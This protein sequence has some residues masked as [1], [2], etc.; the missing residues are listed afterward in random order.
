MKPRTS[1]HTHTRKKKK[2][3]EK[4]K[5]KKKKHSLVYS[6]SPTK[7]FLLSIKKKEKSLN[8]PPASFKITSSGLELDAQEL[9]VKSVKM[10]SGH[11][12]SESTSPPMV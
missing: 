4:K 6:G 3:K 5:K 2:K 9:G 1:H 8:L 10:S 7:E 12:K 11:R